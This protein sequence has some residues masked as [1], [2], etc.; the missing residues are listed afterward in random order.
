[1]SAPTANQIAR[2]LDER[3]LEV[4]RDLFPKGRKRGNEYVVGNLDGAAGKSLKIHL[5]GS[6]KGTVW[7]D[8]ET[9]DKGGD[10]LDLWATAKCNG[11]KG[12]AMREAADWLGTKPNI[13]SIT[14][15]LWTG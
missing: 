13:S 5:N 6:G 1:M 15:K 14:S 9:E 4:C 12:D 7:S 11:D 8:F 2:A 10:L 3:P